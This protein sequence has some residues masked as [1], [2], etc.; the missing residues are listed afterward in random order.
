MGYI[1]NIKMNIKKTYTNY[2]RCLQTLEFTGVAALA[3]YTCA[4]TIPTPATPHT[5]GLTFQHFRAYMSL[6]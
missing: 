1:Y 3:T 5:W 6:P 4:Y 2:T